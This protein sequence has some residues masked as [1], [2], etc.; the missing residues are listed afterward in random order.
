M[1]KSA[2]AWKGKSLSTIAEYSEGHV[3]R[4]CLPSNPSQSSGVCSSGS[5]T[6]HDTV[7]ITYQS[8]EDINN[9]VVY[10]QDETNS[11]RLMDQEA[12]IQDAPARKRSF[13]A[14][15]IK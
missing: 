13:D 14:L 4:S 7:S 9:N 11:Q 10:V 2:S 12:T 15:S 3:L 1:P 5:R 6:L 8:I